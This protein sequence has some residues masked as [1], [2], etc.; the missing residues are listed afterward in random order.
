VISR[1]SLGGIT[2]RELHT[3]AEYDECVAI[4]KETWGAPF[5]E[6][7]PASILMICQKVGGV[8]AGAFGPDGRMLGFVFGLTGI[9]DGRP[10]HWSHMLAVRD[11]L[12]GSGLGQQLKWYQRTL[13]LKRGVD[14]MYWTFDPLVSRNAHLNLNRLGAEIQAYVPDY[15]GAD[16]DSE[17]H[18]GLGTDRFIVAWKLRGPRTRRAQAGRPVTT[19]SRHTDAP[20]VDSLT[21]GDIGSIPEE[22]DL[23]DSEWVRVEVPADIQAVKKHDPG[24]AWQWRAVTRRA[25]LHYLAKG[26][27]VDGIYRDA[28]GRSF[29]VLTSRQDQRRTSGTRRRKAGERG[30][31]TRRRAAGGGRR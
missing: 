27:G 28:D 8:V 30:P 6:I 23:P 10:A 11:D 12:R 5:T 19:Y 2:F 1:R 20:V 18:S 25:F 24:V 16:T 26:Y 15:Y 13:L 3:H 31:R 21:V 17:L 29:Y 22:R 9:K 4:Q 14:V 7:V